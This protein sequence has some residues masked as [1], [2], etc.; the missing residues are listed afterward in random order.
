MNTIVVISS[1]MRPVIVF[2][3]LLSPCAKVVGATNVPTESRFS[4][5]SVTKIVLISM[6]GMINWPFRRRIFLQKAQRAHWHLGEA[7]S[8][9]IFGFKGKMNTLL[10]IIGF[11]SSSCFAKGTETH[12]LSR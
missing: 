11:H 1:A 9:N 12:V 7:K 5:P 2:R 4:F 10:G 3:R 8:A 6:L